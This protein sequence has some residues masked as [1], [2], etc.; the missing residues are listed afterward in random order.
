[1]SSKHDLQH[2]YVD[3]EK[4]KKMPSRPIK[5]D[6]RR[7]STQEMPQLL[8]LLPFHSETTFAFSQQR[9]PFWL[10]NLT[11]PKQLQKKLSTLF[12]QLIDNRNRNTLIE[13]DIYIYTYISR[14]YGIQQNQSVKPVSH[15]T[16]ASL[17]RM[18][19]R[20]EWEKKKSV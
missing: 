5:H 11:K 20:G 13:I 6:K 2:N 17:G 19:E 18:Y 8:T 7:P 3:V 16:E 4:K 12:I 1:M 15:I 14:N 9:A 10:E